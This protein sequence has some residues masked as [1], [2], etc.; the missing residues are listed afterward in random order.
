MAIAET[1]G[2]YLVAVPQA[3]WHRQIARR[4]L[5]RTSLSRAVQAEVLAASEEDRSVPHPA[6]K[7]RVWLGFLDGDLVDCVSFVSADLGAEVQFCVAGAEGEVPA[8][9][10]APS[11]TAI[12]A[13]HFTFM[14][15]AEGPELL[16]AR[17]ADDVDRRLS[18]LETGISRMQQ[19]LEALVSS[20]S[21]SPALNAEL[22]RS[23]GPHL[24][25][26]VRPSFGFIALGSNPSDDPTRD[27]PLR[28]P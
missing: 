24:G 13:E 15:A 5:P 3:A 11:L 25:S 2:S 23:I 27:V 9:P 19:S 1:Q 4:Y 12:A 8:C 18:A 26:G 7:V 14:S 20:R 21:G 10:F 22:R 6:Y 17:G 16:K 28:A